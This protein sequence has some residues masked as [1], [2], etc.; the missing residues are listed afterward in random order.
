M[1][2]D[3]AKK[4]YGQIR[5]EVISN[6]GDNKTVRRRIEREFEE[7]KTD[8][9]K[10]LYQEIIDDLNAPRC[11]DCRKIFCWGSFSEYYCMP[12]VEKYSDRRPV[13][14]WNK[15]CEQFEP[16]RTIKK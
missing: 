4:L 15:A 13:H 8:K 5:W 9:E 12:M 16:K 6:Y 14:K 2:S 1:M 11:K 10:A 3:E 7:A